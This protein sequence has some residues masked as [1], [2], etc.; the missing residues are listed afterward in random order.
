MFAGARSE[1]FPM[2]EVRQTAKERKDV[3]SVRDLWDRTQWAAEWS[4]GGGSARLR[5]A[6][7]TWLAP[8]E[9]IDQHS[10]KVQRDK[11]DGWSA[12]FA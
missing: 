12:R 1:V 4:A 9:L 6:R 5:L 7:P 11:S 2:P 10:R 8:T 3:Y